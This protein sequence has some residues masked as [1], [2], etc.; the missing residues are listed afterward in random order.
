MVVWFCTKARL[1]ALITG[2]LGLLLLVNISAAEQSAI[3]GFQPQGL[4]YAGIYQLKQTDPNLTGAGVKIALVSRSITYIDGEPQN[5]YR[6]ASDHNCFKDTQYIFHDQ[7]LLAAGI[8][9]HSTAVCSILFGRDSSASDEQIGNFNYEGVVPDAQANVYEFWSFLVNN[10]FPCSAPDADIITAD[11]GYQFEDWWTRGIEAM[12]QKY[13]LTVV[14]GIG[15]GSYSSDPVLFPGAG[16]NVIGVG[17]VKSAESNDVNAGLSR[18]ALVYPEYS[19]MGPTPDARCKPDIVAPG[20]CLAAVVG[21]PN[22]YEPTGDWSSFA[23]PVVAG[24]AALLIQQ[25]HADPNLQQAVSHDGGDCVVKSILLNSATKLPY[26]HKGLLTKADDHDVPLDY[27]QGAGMVNAAAASNQLLAGQ[28]LPGDCPTA[29]WDLNKLNRDNAQ[30]N[31][32]K[33]RITEPADKMITATVT[34]NRQF[35]L[36]YPFEH[37][38]QKDADLRIEIWAVDSNDPNNNYLL[39]YS[40]SRIDNVEHVY[41][42]VDANFTDYEIVVLFSD[43]HDVNQPQVSPPYAVAWNVGQTP[44][45]NDALWFDLNG[46]GVVDDLDVSVLLDNLIA[47]MQ[48]SDRYLFGDIN[49]DGVIDVSDLDILMRYIDAAAEGR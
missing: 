43:E 39:D 13:G 37:D 42:P 46:D 4:N 25:A 40:D 15:N 48:T 9:A 2:F 27:L 34:W 36:V 31:V 19:S 3:G 14:V 1:S 47:G 33:I 6:P 30:E 20:N 26:W 21:E 11:I 10:V 29:G 24:A 45:R 38:I 35:S 8:S 49:S 41:T 32:Y 28:H 16:S 44:V 12:A 5:D 17:V 23:T 7:Q 18:F 22:L